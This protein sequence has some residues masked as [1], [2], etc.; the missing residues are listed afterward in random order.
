MDRLKYRHTSN[1]LLKALS[2]NS[3]HVT[4]QG[5]KL[6]AVW[7]MFGIS[8]WNEAAGFFAFI[9]SFAAFCEYA[10]KKW[11]RP[12]LVWRGILQPLPKRVKLVEVEDE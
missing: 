4:N 10:W 7:A 5:A 1:S 8:S 6:A 12:M 9:V 2:M 11:V 3:E